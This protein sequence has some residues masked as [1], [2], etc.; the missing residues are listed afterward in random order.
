VLEIMKQ[1]KPAE[2]HAFLHQN[3]EAVLFDCRSEMEHL[4][5]GRSR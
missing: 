4:F 5:V 3:P 1:L 2:T